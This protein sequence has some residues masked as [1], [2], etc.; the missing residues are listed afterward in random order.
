M[1][2]KYRPG[3]SSEEAT[4]NSG[5]TKRPFVFGYDFQTTSSE[6]TPRGKVLL[7]CVIV[8]IVLRGHS[9][10][11]KGLSKL[12]IDVIVLQLYI[13]FCVKD[14]HYYYYYFCSLIQNVDGL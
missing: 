11:R 14:F 3:S 2:G 4:S 1:T 13:I 12:N 5:D 6:T 10:K 9:E 7:L 8:K